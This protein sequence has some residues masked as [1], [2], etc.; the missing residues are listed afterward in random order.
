MTGG[1]RR[2]LQQE[3]TR[4]APAFARRTR[5]RFDA[6]DVVGFARVQPHGSVLEVGAGTGNFL[7]LFEGIARRLVAVDL[8]R[9]MLAQARA[10]LEGVQIV[11]ADGARLPLASRSIDLTTSA[12]ALH[13]IFEPLPVL[14]EMRRVTAT[15]GRVLLVDQV[16]TE[17]YE[18]MAFMN[19]LEALRDPT[20][21][22]S[23]PP[24]VVRML[25]TAA[26]LE[27][28]DEVL[29]EERSTLSGWMWPQEFGEERIEKVR[30]FI[31]RFGA[32]TG[33]G[34]ERAGDD[35]S[36]TRR[37]IMLLAGR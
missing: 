33:M 35:W 21:A 14:K 8:T 28:I 2:A 16:A 24:S 6:L 10:R 9:P 22:A 36:F 31:Q 26:G 1:D 23:R 13:H 34:F 7:G 32:E 15:D 17:S 20:H 5:G 29:H 3:F 11:Q 4:A 27:I 18:E 25:V 30:G 12:Q 19:E 37:R